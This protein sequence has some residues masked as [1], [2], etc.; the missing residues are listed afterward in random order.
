M[1]LSS[2]IPSLWIPAKKLLL[3]WVFK[4]P[5]SIFS[6][7]E[8][9]PT[10][11]FYIHFW[12]TC[13]GYLVSGTW[14]LSSPWSV[15]RSYLPVTSDTSFSSKNDLGSLSLAF[16]TLTS[17]PGG[18]N[19]KRDFEIYNSGSHLSPYG[20]SEPPG[21]SWRQWLLTSP[22]RHRSSD[23]VSLGWGPEFAFVTSS[24]LTLM[25][26]VWRPHFEDH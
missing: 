10:G 14:D 21:V 26:L 7:V 25:L 4:E 13:E 20:A 2:W 6:V 1:R 15:L 3:G 19:W 11:W 22:Y 9:T 8:R 17:F 18:L 23:P 5:M 16:S 12:L 24:Q